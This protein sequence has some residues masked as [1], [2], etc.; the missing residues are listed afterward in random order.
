M[1]VYAPPSRSAEEMEVLAR[2]LHLAAALVMPYVCSSLMQIAEAG[3][4]GFPLA[5][6]QARG[7]PIF[8]LVE[9]LA[10]KSVPMPPAP[11][12]RKNAKQLLRHLHA[13]Y[14]GLVAFL[15]A[16]G[17][18]LAALKSE[19]LLNLEDFLKVSAERHAAAAMG[20]GAKERL[21][22]SRRKQLEAEHKLGHVESWLEIVLQVVKTLVLARITPKSFRLLPGITPQD[23]TAVLKDPTLAGS[24]VYTPSEALVL[25][26]LEMHWLRGEPPQPERLTGFEQLR[27]G[28]VFAA[29][30]LSHCPF[31]ASKVLKGEEPKAGTAI[32]L[33]VPRPVNG[34][35]AALVMKEA[36][37]LTNM[38]L[39][40]GALEQ[41][42]LLFSA[43]PNGGRM[44]EAAALLRGSPRELLLFS[45][46]LYQS[47]PHYV[48]KTT[49]EFSGAP[50]RHAAPCNQRRQ[51][52]NLM[53]LEPVASR[54]HPLLHP[55]CSQPSLYVPRLRP[56][57]YPGGLHAPLAKTL[58]LSNP[59]KK[60][61]TYAV[62]LEGAPCF[63][64]PA[65]SVRIESKG[66]HAFP[67]E[68]NSRFT[69]EAT[70]RLLFI[71]RGDG[72]ATANATTLVFSLRANTSIGAPMQS[73]AVESRLYQVWP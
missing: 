7:R 26:W 59:S 54:R 3:S 41:I 68:V 44:V 13:S 22:R 60:P 40:M 57:L 11:Q 71:S 50:Q 10:G 2:E 14:D 15:R 62:R 45:M 27:D 34:A 16:H 65:D 28:H 19:Y 31:L 30:V 55:G 69:G 63:R 23:A 18:M 53:Q 43:A 5:M 35:G 61:I 66:A 64:L 47:L 1:E 36:D 9:V 17:A 46:F 72:S 70:G 8:E 39:V 12:D 38:K 4:A 29:V 58:E 49:L 52:C 51:P 32:D 42:G 37:Q 6:V 67:V 21:S 48:P 25:R 20:D 56:L 24:N 73:A 33:L